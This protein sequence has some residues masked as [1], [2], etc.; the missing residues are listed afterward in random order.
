MILRRVSFFAA[1]FFLFFGAAVPGTTAKRARADNRASVNTQSL[2][3]EPFS[4]KVY[5][6][7]EAFSSI[8]APLVCLSEKRNGALAVLLTG[9]L[10]A[11][12]AELLFE[13]CFQKAF[14]IAERLLRLMRKRAP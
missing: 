4:M 5:Y 1:A 2:A 10:C 8:K 12:C 9:A 13:L 6:P 14:T 7:E 3:G 11:P